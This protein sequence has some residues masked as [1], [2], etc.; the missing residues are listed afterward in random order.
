MGRFA[1]AV[2]S[3]DIV[4]VDTESDSFY[5]YREKVCLIQVS[6]RD[7]DILVDP[8][9][10][11][12][13]TVF[14]NLL[15]DPGVTKV[16]HAAEND[17]ILLRHHLDIGVRGVF[18][19]LIAAQVLGIEQCS[20]AGLLHRFFGLELSKKEQRSDWRRRPLTESQIQYAALDTHHLLALREQLLERLVE[21]GRVDEAESDFRLLENKQ[22]EPRPFRAD[23]FARIK[24]AKDLDPLGVRILR[25]LFVLRNRLAQESDTAPFRIMGDATLMHLARRRP[26]RPHDLQDI[27]SFPRR[28]RPL[29]G[30][31][32]ETIRAARELGPLRLPPPPD[33]G[34]A[35]PRLTPEE[36]RLFDGLRKWRDAQALERGVMPHRVLKNDLLLAFVRAAPR[37]MEDVSRIEALDAWRAETYGPAVLLEMERLHS[38]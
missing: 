25:E 2:E 32:L 11:E 35:R 22:W 38:G 3:A 20:L 18:D 29:A 19:T 10:V 13:L 24:G 23:D 4:G 1:L 28:G 9:G 34:N 37:N 15:E 30:A 16:F 14:R 8:L 21:L 6:T 36:S 33:R 5:A 7:Q 12:D 31:V 17:V 27:R 26:T